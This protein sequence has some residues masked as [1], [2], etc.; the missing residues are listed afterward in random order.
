MSLC[1]KLIKGVLRA[2]NLSIVLEFRISY[3]KFVNCIHAYIQTN[4]HAH[5]HT[6]AVW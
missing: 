1:A 2:G 3:V 4:K 5:V 6:R